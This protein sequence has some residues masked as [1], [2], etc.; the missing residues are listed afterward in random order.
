MLSPYHENAPGSPEQVALLFSL[1][2]RRFQ[3]YRLPYRSPGRVGIRWS[4]GTAILES[5]VESVVV[6][7]ELLSDVRRMETEGLGFVCVRPGTLF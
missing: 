3:A 5:D 7:G 2:P 1:K 6:E 4:R